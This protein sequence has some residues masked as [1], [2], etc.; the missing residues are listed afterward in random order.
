MVIV[1]NDFLTWV[2]TPDNKLERERAVLICYQPYL[3]QKL[4]FQLLRLLLVLLL[5][6]KKFQIKGLYGKKTTKKKQ[7]K[8]RNYFSN[9]IMVTHL[10]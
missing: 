10:V 2:Y 9:I 5:S 7:Q 8:D 4:S 3:L 1:L 6:A